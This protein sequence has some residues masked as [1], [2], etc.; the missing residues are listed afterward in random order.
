[1][2]LQYLGP[3]VVDDPEKFELH[4]FVRNAVALNVQRVYYYR[5]RL[6]V[7]DYETLS[8]IYEDR[9]VVVEVITH[10]TFA[11]VDSFRRWILYHSHNDT[12]EH[13][14]SVSNLRGDTAVIPVVKTSDRFVRKIDEHIREGRFR[15]SKELREA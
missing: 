2:N 10:S 8:G 15:I 13:T 9:F 7:I 12:Y 4:D 3:A 1:M 6:F 5:N 14:D 11:E